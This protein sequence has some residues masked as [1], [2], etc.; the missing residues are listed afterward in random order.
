MSPRARLQQALGASLEGLGREP[1]VIVVGASALLVIAHYEGSAAS[2]HALWGSRFDTHPAAAA[3]GH[4][5][6]FAASVFFYLLA[7]LALSWATRGSF[8]RR[9]GL[10]LGDW[11]AGLSISALF[12]AVMLPA[13]FLASRWDAFRGIYPLAGSA[14]YTLHH[15]G[16]S[17][18]SVSLFAVYEAGYLAYFIAWEFLFRG[19]LVNGLLPHW[20]RS[21]ALLTP[22]LPF[23][24]MH[25]GKA[26]PEA[27]GS[28]IAGLALGILSLRTR[29]FWYGAAV[30]GIV[31][32]WMDWLSARTALL[33]A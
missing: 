17:S 22:V 6:W 2:F 27:L 12:L 20:G 3:L 11:R 7:P 23:A 25:L 30:H 16:R 28:I 8:H 29:S 4:L 15:G 32:L 26:E 18:V 24:V 1:T 31:A 33:G 5:W 21:G 19:W 13:T 9:Y 10:G 14:A